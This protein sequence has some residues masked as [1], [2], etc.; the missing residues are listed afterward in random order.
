MFFVAAL[1]CECFSST[2]LPICKYCTVESLNSIV[3][4]ISDTLIIYLLLCRFAIIDFIKRKSNLFS[5]IIFRVLE[6]YLVVI[7]VYLNYF[8][9]LFY[10]LQVYHWSASNNYI[11]FL[12]ILFHY[13]LNSFYT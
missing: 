10:S 3:D 13:I 7:I 11:Y 1:H 2:C 5:C 4:H 8:F 9:A 6:N 12:F